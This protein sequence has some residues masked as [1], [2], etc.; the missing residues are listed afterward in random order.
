MRALGSPSIAPIGP[1]RCR[2]SAAIFTLSNADKAANSRM[3][4]NVR[5]IP[6]R[7]TTWGFRLR[8]RRAEPVT[9]CV[10]VP[11]AVNS[12]VPSCGV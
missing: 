10:V 4:W 1:V 5:A 9:S 6:I 12:I 8:R 2:V 7:F 3:F 11:S